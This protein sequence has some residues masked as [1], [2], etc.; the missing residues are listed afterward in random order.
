MKNST[1]LFKNA[2]IVSSQNTQIADVLIKNKKIAKIADFLSVDADFF[3]DLKEKF[4]LP[5]GIDPH[6]HMNLPTAAGFSTDNF[7]TGS[8]A[9]LAGG[10]TTL[11]DFVTPE[12]GQSLIEAYKNRIN[13]T[14]GIQTNVKFHVSPI[15]WTD[16]TGFE[17][18]ELV[19]NYG[20]NS[21]KI[22][23]AYKNSIG[24]ND[25]DIIKVMQ[26]AKDLGAIVTAHCEND[27]IIDFL[28]KKFISEGKT[29]PIY[30]PLS[31][32]ADAE[33]EAIKKMILFSEYIQTPIYIVHVSTKDGI[34][35]IAKAQSR[36][37][38]IF[39]ETCPHYLLLNDNVYNQEFNQAAKYVL[40]PPIRKPK[41]NEGLWEQI[42][43]GVVQT[44]GTDHCPF[45]TKGQKDKGINDFTKIAN[46][47]GSVEN[48]MLLL[49]TYGV[50]TGKISMQKFI[51]ITSTN[52]ANIFNLKTKGKIEVGYD[53]DLIVFNP[54]F[55]S[56]ISAQTQFQ[57]CDNS[58]YEGYEIDGKIEKAFVNGEIKIN[59]E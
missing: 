46:G 43:N 16:T 1:I 4:L 56:I 19:E 22:Y 50:K 49:Y 37:V 18:K 59:N 47:A 9:A 20:V 53:A 38:K 6:V 35:E 23:L 33:V 52:P 57:N 11:I 12:K 54:D 32:P 55:K 39:A 40:S 15:E 8:K 45:N 48:R 41:D 28:R 58:I 17:M 27:E 10:T 3:Y 36:K 51:E 21:F 42:K 24:L 2:K 14:S 26:T 31:R 29:Q 13:E 30:H 7:I 34:D 25:K 44:I 5:G